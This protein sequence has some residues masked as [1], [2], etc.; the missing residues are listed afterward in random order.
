MQ[1]SI[2]AV[3]PVGRDAGRRSGSSARITSPMARTVPELPAPGIPAAACGRPPAP[4][5]ARAARRGARARSAWRRS[6]RRG[7][8][9]RW[10]PTQPI[11]RL[12]SSSGL[13]PSPMISSVL[14]PPM[15]TTRRLPGLVRHGV[16]DP[17]IDEARLFHA[18][19]DL[20]R[21]TERLAGA[22]EE[23]LLAL[24]AA[25]AH[26]CPPRARCR[27]ACRAGAGRSAAGSASARAATSLS[28]RPFSRDAGGE[29]HHLAQPI[30][31]DQLAVR[32]ARDHHVEAVGAQV[33]RRQHVRDGTRGITGR[34]TGFGGSEA[35]SRSH[36]RCRGFRRPRR[37]NRSRRWWRRS[38][39]G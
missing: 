4:A 19:D 31:D 14:P 9:A 10:R 22:L 5:R 8:S 39:C 35:G 24:C 23:R 36:A 17:G 27:H 18:G 26:W 28:M 29:A 16:R 20:D 34:G 37:R 38:G 33:D 21:V 12:S 6:C 25:A 7:R 2:G 1:Y 30:D 3:E 15:S 11:C 32:I 13:K